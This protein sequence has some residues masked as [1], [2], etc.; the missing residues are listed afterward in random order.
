MWDTRTLCAAKG[1]KLGGNPSGTGDEFEGAQPGCVVVDIGHDHELVSACFRNERIHAGTNRI[2]RADDGASEHTH[3]LGFLGMMLTTALLRRRRLDAAISPTG[4]SSLLSNNRQAGWIR[5][6][7]SSGLALP[8]LNA[9]LNAGLDQWRRECRPHRARFR[10]PD[11]RK[12]RTFRHHSPPALLGRANPSRARELLDLVGL[13]DRS[14]HNPAQLSGGE[15]QRVA[16]ARA[17]ANDPALVLADEPTG[18]LDDQSAQMVMGLLTEAVRQRGRTLLL[19]THER[20][21]AQASDKSLELRG[22]LLR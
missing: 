10:R 8:G 5:L 11:P 2:V 15:Q 6:R 18:N 12:N 7:R 19:V 4:W 1:I 14:D 20:D 9:G 22:G 17:L 16:V 13:S 21:T 3:R